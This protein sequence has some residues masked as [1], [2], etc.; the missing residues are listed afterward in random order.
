MPILFTLVRL[1]EE[2]G[3][4]QPVDKT[5]F[6]WE[7]LP[8]IQ[9]SGNLPFSKCKCNLYCNWWDGAGAYSIEF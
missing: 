6:Q 8:Q 1:L 7:Y 2:F 3:N 4:L 9:V 5:G